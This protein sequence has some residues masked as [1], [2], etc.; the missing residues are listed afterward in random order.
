[1]N[2]PAFLIGTA[3]ALVTA[4]LDFQMLF[5]GQSALGL[6]SFIGTLLVFASSM[7]WLIYRDDGK[8]YFRRL[9]LIIPVFVLG[10]A[11]YSTFKQMPILS[12]QTPESLNE[13]GNL[14]MSRYQIGLWLVSISIFFVFII[15]SSLMVRKRL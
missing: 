6:F 1:M 9:T 15:S 2:K 8:V 10:L 5:M 4:N 11:I 13:S 3:I 7:I 12:L 14:L